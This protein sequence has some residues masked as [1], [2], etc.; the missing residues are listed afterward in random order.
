M[1]PLFAALCFLTI[2]FA[3]LGASMPL[4]LRDVYVPHIIAPDTDTVWN[5]GQYGTVSWDSSNLPKEVTNSQGMV[6]LFKDGLEDIEHPLASGFDVVQSHSI[7]FT[8]PKVPPKSDYQ[9]VLFGD[10]GNFSPKFTIKC[11]D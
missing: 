7:S 8:V 9:I 10:S 4:S 2:S 1:S 6:V 5:C 3:S 11:D